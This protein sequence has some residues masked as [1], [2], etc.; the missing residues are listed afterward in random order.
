MSRARATIA[1][2]AINNLS[3]SR[4]VKFMRHSVLSS[5][6]SADPHFRNAK[7]TGL[8]SIFEIFEDDN[9]RV[10]QVRRRPGGQPDDQKA[11]DQRRCTHASKA[12]RKLPDHL[13]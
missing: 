4:G 11:V 7:R 12:P 10:S 9:Q 2:T 13:E 8:A 6:R 5:R 1:A 3:F